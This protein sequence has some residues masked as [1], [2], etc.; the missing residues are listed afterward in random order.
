MN[1][2]EIRIEINQNNTLMK[3]T[4]VA[5]TNDDCFDYIFKGNIYNN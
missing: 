3:K 1:F 4:V 2:F 5:M